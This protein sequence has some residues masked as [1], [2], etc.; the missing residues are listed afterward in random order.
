M[1]K[2]KFDRSKP[3]CNIGTLG[4]VD[5]GK[6]TLTAAIC[7]TLAAKGLAVAKSFD[8]IDKAPEEKVNGVSINISRV[9]YDTDNRHYS[10]CDCPGFVNNVKNLVAGTKKMDGAILVVAATDGPMPQT[11]ELI[12]LA[13][14]VG[15]KKIVVFMNKCDMVDDAEILDLVEMEVRG[16][17]TKYGFDGDDTPVIHGSALKALNGDP[18]YQ[19]KIIE[20]MDACDEYIPLQQ[21]NT[22]KPF[23]MPIEDVCTISGRGTVA[24]GRIERGLVH[25]NDTVQRVGFGQNAEFV[26]V[27]IE[28][29]RK[30]L[31]EGQPG[32]N[33]GLLLRGAEK[34][35]LQRGQILATPNSLSESTDFDAEVYILTKDEGGRQTPFMNG[36]CPQFVFRTA[37]VSGGVVLLNNAEMAVPGQLVKIH[38]SLASSVAMENGQRFIIREG[39]K[40]VGTGTITKITKGLVASD[41][42]SR[43][44]IGTL[45]SSNN[46]PSLAKTIVKTFLDHDCFASNYYADG[47]VEFESANCHYVLYNYSNYVDYFKNVAKGRSPLEGA[48]VVAD[49]TDTYASQAGM[50]LDLAQRMG[51]KDVVVFINNVENAKDDKTLE[52]IESRIRTKLYELKFKGNAVPIIRG[53]VSKAYNGDK[54][55]QAGIIKLVDTCDSFI[56]LPLRDVDKPFLMHINGDASSSDLGTVV[57]GRVERGIVRMNDTIER[58]GFG[59]SIEIEVVGIEK[60]G[61]SLD[62]AQAGDSLTLTLAGVKKN[63]LKTKQIL[64]APKTFIMQNDFKAEIY[65]FTKNEGGRT[66]SIANS[67]STQFVFDNASVGG[68]IVLPKNMSTLELGQLATVDIN[69]SSPMALERQQHFS[70]C[71][72]NRTIGVGV[73][74]VI[75]AR[76]CSGIFEN[77]PATRPL[78]L[79]PV[80]LETSFRYKKIKGKDQKQLRVR[81]I[82][83]ELML[84]Y[85]KN[86]KLT[87]EEV[88]DGKFFWVQWYIASGCEKREKEAWDTLC[89]KYPLY[90]AAWICDMLRPKEFEKIRKGGDYFYRRPYAY[91]GDDTNVTSSLDSIENKCRK[92]YEILSNINYN[93][94]EILKDVQKEE[95]SFEKSIRTGLGEINSFIF[96]IE[97]QLQSC[98]KIVDYLYDNVH[99]TFVY[100]QK[101]LLVLQSVYIKLPELQK[102]R[103]LELW[104]IDYSILNSLIEKTAQFL[105]LLD[106]RRITLPDMVKMYLEERKIEFSRTDIATREADKPIIPVCRCLPDKFALIAEVANKNKDVIYAVSKDVKT[107]E[108]QMGFNMDPSDLKDELGL[109]SN[110]ELNLSTKMKWLTDYDV[111]EKNGMAITVNV[112]DDVKE[113]RYI[114]V[115]GVK[116]NGNSFVLNDL[117]YGHNYVNSNMRILDAGTPTN[118]IDEEYVSD[119]E[120]LKDLRYEI[121]VGTAY[122]KIPQNFDTVEKI[123]ECLN[124]VQKIIND[125]TKNHKSL[126][127]TS[128]FKDIVSKFL[129]DKAFLGNIHPE[130]DDYLDDYY[131]IENFVENLKID[132]DTKKKIKTEIEPLKENLGNLRNKY[133]NES[134]FDARKIAYL[135]KSSENSNC[136]DSDLVKVWARTIG[137]DSRQNHLAKVAYTAIW[138][139]LVS[140]ASWN[141]AFRKNSFVKEFFINHVRARGNV[142]AFRIDDVP[143]GILPTSDF[144]QLSKYLKKSAGDEDVYYLL[145]ALIKLANIWHKVRND[146]TKWSEVLV[147][148]D[149]QKN[150]LEMAG[151]TPYSVDFTERVLVDMPRGN[152]PDTNLERKTIFKFLNKEFGKTFPVA[153][154]Y[155]EFGDVK[156]SKYKELREKVLYALKVE[157]KIDQLTTDEINESEEIKELNAKAEKEASLFVAEFLD[158]FSYRIDAWFLGIIDY[159]YHKQIRSLNY[160]FI[161]AFG[162]VFN[163]KEDEGKR[164]PVKNMNKVVNDMELKLKPSETLFQAPEKAHFIT[165]PSIQHALTAAVLR[166]SFLNAKSKNGTVNSEIC[167]NLSSARVRQ[168]MRLVDGVKSG[169]SLSIILGSDFERYLHEAYHVYGVYMDEY[170]YNLRMLFPQITQIASASDERANDYIMQVVNGEAMINSFVEYW[171]WNGSVAKWLQKEWNERVTRRNSEDNPLC[172]LIKCLDECVLNN[173]ID[174]K[175]FDILFKIIERLMDSYDA[176]NDLLLSEGVHRLV[177]GDKASYYAISNFLSSGDGNL[178]DMDILNI[179]SEH[180]VVTHKAGVLLPQSSNALNKVMCHAEPALNAWIENQLGGMENVLVFIEKFNDEKREIIPCSLKD[181]GISGI[182]Y[183]Y[184][185]AFDKTFHAYLEARIRTTPKFCTSDGF[186]TEN[187]TILD[188]AIDAGYVYQGSQIS[189]EDNKLTLEA[190]RGLVGRARAMNTADWCSSACQDIA[191]EELIDIDDLKNRLSLSRAKL[192]YLKNDLETWLDRTKGNVAIDD[193]L[194]ADAYKLLCDCFESGLITS[195]NQYETS[196]FLGNLTQTKSPLDYDRICNIQQ[197]LYHSVEDTLASLKDRMED[198]Q[199]IIDAGKTVESYIAALQAIT[200]SNFKVCYKFKFAK[201]DQM[202]TTPM[203][204]S[205]EFYENLSEESFG[206]W[207]DEVSEVREGMKLMNQLQMTQMAMDRELDQVSILQTTVPEGEDSSNV[208]T[209]YKEWLGVEVRDESE[210][211]DADSLVLYNSAAYN[212]KSLNCL[213]GFVFD[214][215]IEYIPYKK[216][217]AGFAFHNDWPDNEAPQAMLIA[218]HPCLPNLQNQDGVKWDIK[219]LIQIIR[220]TRFMMMN[221][222]LE[223]D[224]VYNDELLSRIFPITPKMGLEF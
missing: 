170:I 50:Q 92:V 112:K 99:E 36:Y 129:V 135:L 7:T 11:R 153:D 194:V 186:Y 55:A 28:M 96:S 134:D 1:A 155:Q 15:M 89:S 213:S 17:L 87:A 145:R 63:E 132:A 77:I 66:N 220:S 43:C 12:L 20:L 111:A 62:F 57:K 27:G 152:S 71:E 109:D 24:I 70:I 30:I 91:R 177:M 6:T 19:S 208:D 84:D 122:K 18:Q 113:F 205:L 136:F 167:V 37:V 118:L 218:M 195:L 147:G 223:P 54:A 102:P 14:Q 49:A 192:E 86:A 165:A 123:T 107:S 209:L 114:Y 94:G 162:W 116:S 185:S 67:H 139:Y 88:E 199:K 173:Q 29:F 40:I 69:L 65:L 159:C 178:P 25:L 191:E 130:K 95:T 219:T 207:Q 21:S 176:L 59:D 197:D 200:L 108:I 146:N 164:I 97:S 151:Q 149:V 47:H 34:N 58:V 42:K 169:M 44:T 188:S 85:Y 180:V 68:T 22:D 75:K 82:P 217:D 190:I 2:E 16:L 182:E 224:H 202:F 184:L 142:A 81:I 196:A 45:L 52:R 140:K 38:V 161:G 183:L 90:K 138:D 39:D 157:Y 156:N 158:L 187:I 163:L 128:E 174:E 13:Q 203:K 3:L 210:L 201:V 56:H 72:G 53:S 193:S 41:S 117:F 189:L 33:V 5:H 76:N 106:R 120:K 181:L 74:T 93:E 61:K 51:I 64:A 32:D 121:E 4:H 204:D 214:S 124:K 104:D 216:H 100:L 110:G 172:P 10:H 212:T 101:H 83:D 171:G 119:E 206:Q 154:L 133:F 141:N 168:A 46:D 211:R 48:I 125:L 127:E 80:R 221:R 103:S 160:G 175:N 9:G 31:D 143:Y 79:L 179:P 105:D 150:Y 144:I 222:A 115:V 73:V 35:D 166:S 131:K 26:V 8:E 137:G 60:N 23:L 78:I 198:A 215:W 126:F 98:D 148:E